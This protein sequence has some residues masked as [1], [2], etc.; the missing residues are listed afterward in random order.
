MHRLRRNFFRTPREPVQ[1][2][3][4]LASWIRMRRSDRQPARSPRQRRLLRG[5]GATLI[6]LALLLVACGRQPDSAAPD[7]QRAPLVSGRGATPDQLKGAARLARRF[8]RVYARGAYRRRPPSI[9]REARGVRQV[10]IAAARRV[11][12]RRRGL[13]PRLFALRLWLRR[14]GR[15]GVLARIGDGRFSLFSVGFTIAPRGRGWLI[16]SFDSPD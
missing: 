4:P 9:R 3:P 12:R 10:L 2:P 5:A 8:A 1:R 13:H 11:P 15:V 7:P 14:R 6:S 16:T